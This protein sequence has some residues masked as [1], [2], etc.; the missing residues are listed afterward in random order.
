[1]TEN[2]QALSRQEQAAV[3][4]LDKSREEL[5]RFVSELVAIP[6][7]TGNEGEASALVHDWLHRNGFDVRRE[8]VD[9][10]DLER[11]PQCAG[12][13]DLEN[14]PNV[15]GELR[16]AGASMGDFV[17]NGH[18]D[19]VPTGDPAKWSRDPFSGTR[20]D[21][22]IWGRG[23]ADM[24]GGIGAA[25]F[26]LRALRDAGVELP[27]NVQVQCV[28]AEES[29]GLGTLA[30]MHGA[31][32]PS[33]ALVLEPTECNIVTACGGATPFTLTVNGTAAHVALPWT[34]V[35][36]YEKSRLV[37]DRLM[38]LERERHARLTHPMFDR[39]PNK[40]PLSIGKVE[41]GEWRLTIPD[42]ARLYGRVGTLPE[43]DLAAVRGELEAAMAG[44]A[45]E[46]DWFRDHPVEVH[47]DGGFDG[48]ETAL[49]S[50]L[51]AGLRASARALDVDIPT[52]CVTYGSD[53]GV[54]AG[55][56][57]PVALFGP[58]SIENAHCKDEYVPES[59][60]A[61]VSRLTALGIARFGATRANS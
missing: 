60:I 31:P 32:A 21:G 40:A 55:L 19:V 42:T 56:G 48:W 46:D 36:A 33:A 14:R 39:L 51:V 4:V 20:E 9:A 7:V 26:A 50:D 43:E 44:L 61:L 29:G 13:R 52:A 57:V 12:E 3:D 18:L 49:D 2:V 41:A 45:A 11:W 17:I 27:F 53:A 58:G 54:F 22:L 35:S 34:G 6:S 28:V 24:K 16:S 8:Y 37:H 10:A 5:L 59:E 15:I 1:M 25:L 30:L 38:A 47:W 23:S